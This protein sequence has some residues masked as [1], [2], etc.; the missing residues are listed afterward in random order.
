MVGLNWLLRLCCCVVNLFCVFVVVMDNCFLLFGFLVI[1][2]SMFVFEY[3]CYGDCIK[4]GLLFFNRIYNCVVFVFVLIDLWS[5]RNEYFLKVD[6]FN[7]WYVCENCIYF[8][9]KYIWGDV[10]VWI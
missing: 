10:F 9:W 5:R 7:L 1:K 2:F 4:C 6:W 3:W 8:C